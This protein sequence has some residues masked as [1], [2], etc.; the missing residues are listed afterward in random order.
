MGVSL[1]HNLTAQVGYA[2]VNADV[3]EKNNGDGFRL[4]FRGPLL[5]IQFRDR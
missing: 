4:N 3:H 1:G 2:Y 5:S